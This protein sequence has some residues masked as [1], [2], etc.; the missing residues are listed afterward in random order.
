VHREKHNNILPH[1]QTRQDRRKLH[2]LSNYFGNIQHK[3]LIEIYR[4]AFG[5]DE[6]LLWLAVL[7]VTAFGIESLGLGSESSQVS[8]VAFPNSV[9]HFIKEV[10]RLI[11]G[12]Y[13]DDN[14]FMAYNRVTAE[15][16]LDLL[17][18]KYDA[19]GI[20]IPPDKIKIVKLSQGFIFIKAKFSITETGRVI[21]RPGRKSITR[22]RQKLHKF[23]KLYTAG[24]MTLKEIRAGYMSWRG[25]IAHFNSRKSV[26]S[27]D[28]L[29]KRLF[30]LSPLVKITQ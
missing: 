28:A 18:D 21:I 19:L 13:M 22:Q 24:E 11:F 6:R 14:Y 25:Y 2:N 4:R 30:G 26:I 15:T 9:D 8:A 29:Y 20:V 3:P 5:E 12:H 17:I 23:Y 10:L 16:T 27:M 1:G 7:F